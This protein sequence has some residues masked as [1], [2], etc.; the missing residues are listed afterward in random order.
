MKTQEYSTI[1]ARTI[2]PAERH[3]KIFEKFLSLHPGHEL[4]VIVDHDPRHLLE[5]MKHEGLPVVVSAYETHRNPDGTFVGVFRRGENPAPTGKVKITSFDDERSF[6]PERFS[7]VGI[8]SGKDYKVIITYIRAGQFIPVHSPDTDLV[9]AVFKGTGMAVAGEN[10]VDLY[11][12][13]LI[14]IPRGEKRGIS[15]KTDIEALHIVSP[16]PTED[17]HREVHEK[18]SKGKFL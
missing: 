13:K 18:L 6:S 17:D 9:F 12:G 1:D 11:P 8:Y 3:A 16:I 5:H 2:A 15:A 10:E 4:H 14:I 7:P